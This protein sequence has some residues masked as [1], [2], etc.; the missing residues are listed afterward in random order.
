MQYTSG[1]DLMAIITIS[2]GTLSGGKKLATMLADTL[3]YRCVSREVITR[4]ADEYGVPEAKLFE[5]IQKGPSIF[6]KL[7]FDRDRYLAYV[8]ATLCEYASEDNLIYHGH[9]GHWLL[10]GIS[11]V[12]SIRLVANMPYRVQAAID[13]F[14][15]SEREAV[16]YIK[17]VDR[18]RV[19]WTKFLY[20]KDWR[21]PALYDIVFNLDRADLHFVCQ[22]VRHAV[23]QPQF[24][25]TPESTNA[26]QDLLTAS[27]VRAA[28]ARLS[29]I[30]LEQIDVKARAGAVVLRGRLKLHE[31]PVAIVDTASQV[32]G[33]YSVDN[34]LEVDYRSYEIE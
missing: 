16:K 26:M 1:D 28:L 25:A 3:G 31:L 22:M 14:G 29:N 10:E 4:T 8:Q 13:Q 32:P 19:K 34:Q 33:V 11:H 23:G 27:R 5:A 17:K 6:Q 20:G 18:E 2:R 9:G 7:T 15:F 24:Q 30:R 21:S 12:L